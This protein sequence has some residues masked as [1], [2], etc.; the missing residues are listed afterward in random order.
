MF[1][2][3]INR[4]YLTLFFISIS[5]LACSQPAATK[6]IS[7]MPEAKE[8]QP[9]TVS[10][11]LINTVPK[12]DSSNPNNSTITDKTTI[13]C[14]LDISKQLLVCNAYPIPN[15]SSHKWSSNI[16]GW[17]NS[18]SYELKLEREYQ[19]NKEASIQL[20]LCQNS[21]CETTEVNIDTYVAKPITKNT[22]NSD[23]KDPKTNQTINT[24]ENQQ[25]SANSNLDLGDTVQNNIEI[26]CDLD[27]NQKK[28]LCESNVFNDDGEITWSSN[29]AGWTHSKTYEIELNKDYQFIKEARIELEKCNGS[30]CQS[31]HTTIN[32]ESLKPEMSQPEISKD[33]HQH[34]KENNRFRGCSGSGEVTF[35]HSPM[36]FE[37]FSTIKP[38]GAV[39]GAHVT[40]ID[41]MYF[42]MADRSLGRDSYEV[43]AIQDGVIYD[44]S[45]RDINVDTGEAKEREWRMDIAH[46]CTFHSYFDLLTSVH[47]DIL[48][49]WEPTQGG[50]NGPWDGIPIKSGQV[51]G[52]IGGQTLDFGVYDYEKVLTGF[53]YPE[54]YEREPWKIHTVDPFPYFPEEIREILLERNLRKVEPLS[55]KIDHDIDGT[56]SGNWFELNTN[57][58]GGVNPSKYWSG[59]LS[60]A[61]DYID[62]DVWIFATGYWPGAT[63][64][65]GAADF[66]I[67]E[68]KIKPDKVEVTDGIIKYDLGHSIYCFIDE[69]TNCMNRPDGSG[70]LFAKHRKENVHSSYEG[71]VLLQMLEDRL[72]KAEVFPG[73]TSDEIENFTSKATVYER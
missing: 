17:S 37:D 27:E 20:Q 66:L 1:K 30:K 36:R 22:S 14:D 73:K 68:P 12:S 59:H 69:P 25:S 45:P 4:L 54:H 34:V 58:Y 13:T 70:R 56:L 71:V 33:N 11:P 46:T 38:Y 67:V 44:L 28:I 52:R 65:S 31:V 49:E 2:S 7:T 47:P 53:I 39:S 3:P 55:G 26:S 8:A 10:Q 35:E 63:D 24:S 32:T 21:T 5:I 42:A 64:G 43:R 61:P 16:G 6:P 50:E 57:W 40:P 48:E 41:H 72:L 23:S 15:N 29:I 62:P 9:E 60:I 51:V 18:K 19:F